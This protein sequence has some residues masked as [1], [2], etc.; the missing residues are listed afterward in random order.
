[1]CRGGAER[2]G[3]TECEEWLVEKR[4]VF[5][6]GQQGGPGTWAS[7][8]TPGVCRR[9]FQVHSSSHV[10]L[11]DSR[12]ISKLQRLAREPGVQ[13]ELCDPSDQGRPL[14]CIVPSV[15]QLCALN[16]TA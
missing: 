5:C 15:M 3:D 4:A 2:E 9:Y 14:V 10:A 12:V 11:S 16:S 6:R 8:V 7:A 13:A 1:M